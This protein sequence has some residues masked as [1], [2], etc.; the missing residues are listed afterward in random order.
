MLSFGLTIDV[1]LSLTVRRTKWAGHLSSSC[2]LS[3]VQAWFSKGKDYILA[4]NKTEIRRDTS[5]KRERLRIRGTENDVGRVR[6]RIKV[7]RCRMIYFKGREKQERW[8]WKV[9][10]SNEKSSAAAYTILWMRNN[11]TYTTVIKWISFLIIVFSI[12]ISL[13]MGPS[14][15]S[16]YWKIT[17]YLHTLWCIGLGVITK[18]SGRREQVWAVKSGACL[19]KHGSKAGIR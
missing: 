9:L 5:L 12:V 13:F 14:C 15:L 4:K 17:N 8:M 1:H 11:K 7:M 2:H 19:L 6:V 10:L 3:W 18:A 16:F